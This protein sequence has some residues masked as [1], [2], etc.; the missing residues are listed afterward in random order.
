MRCPPRNPHMDWNNRGPA[1]L[2][3]D[4]AG[5]VVLQASDTDAG[6]VGEVLGCDTEDR[7]MLR[8]NG[9]GAMP[10]AARTYLRRFSLVILFRDRGS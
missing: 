10:V 4:G 3:G 8:I 6:I 1:I 2:F 9:I 7:E 5:A